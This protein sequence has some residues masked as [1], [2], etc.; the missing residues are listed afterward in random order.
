MGRILTLLLLTLFTGLSARA[1]S[2]NQRH[3]VLIVWDGMR[4]DFVS[5]K[6]TP[7]LA[8]LARS[9][10]TFR[11][12]HCVYLSSTE[13]NG[14]AIS[15]GCYPGRSGIVGNYE[16]RPEIDPLKP[17]RTEPLD[18]VRHGDLVSGGQYIRFP[19]ITELVRK[20][21]GSAVVAGAKPV[22]LLADRSA[23]LSEKD[24]ANFYAGATL[25]PDLLALL[26][27]K[28]GLFPKDTSTDPSR[29]DWTTTAL[30]DSLWSKGVPNF[31]VLWLNE[32]DLTQHRTSPGSERSLAAMGNSDKNLARVLQALEAKGVKGET[33]I[34]IVSDHG[35]STVRSTVDVAD[36]L[37]KAGI[38][39]TREFKAEPLP[40]EVIVASN[41]GSTLVYVIGRQEEVIRRV[42]SF[43]QQAEFSGVI[44][45]RR[46]LPGTF[47][48]HEARIDS[49][50]APDIFLSMRWSAEK[51]LHGVGGM[52]NSDVS[53]YGPGH[54]MHVTLSPF[55]MQATLIAA[56]PHFRK[57]VV[58]TLASGNVDVA[59]TVLW[60]LGIKPP[61]TMDGRILSEALTINGPK[62]SSFEPRQ[63]QASCN[64]GDSTWTQYLNFTEVNGVRYLDE[65]NGQQTRK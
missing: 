2:W 28:H 37:T 63:I 19:T 15:T 25:P 46:R 24:G 39:A 48:L 27:N 35:V 23:R 1:H 17:I 11:N 8:A 33:D 12:H 53:G 60:V 22:A 36:L 31:S 14:T 49:E 16:Y 40:G 20:N 57:G 6:H 32:P 34:L 21:G 64:E 5:D 55:D 7:T 56:G 62:L 38:P 41:A 47:P 42:V 30:V 65:G 26:T 61:R 52:I 45:C 9:G 50:K 29:A 18:V 43:F 59:P 51:N 4:P 44:F 10:V 54:G 13:V 3:V 58:S